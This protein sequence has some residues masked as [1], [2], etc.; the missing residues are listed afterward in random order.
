MYPEP[1]HNFFEYTI[2]KRDVAPAGQIYLGTFLAFSLFFSLFFGNILFFLI[3]LIISIFIFMEKDEEVTDEF[4]NVRVG[5]YQDGFHFANKDYKYK[6]V[7]S[8]SF[9]EEIFGTRQEYLRITFK[10]PAHPDL[11]IFIPGE[12]QKRMVYD[13]IR[14]SVKED[15][16]KELSFTEQI[17]LRFF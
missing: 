17:V 1:L 6:D 13:I 10:S 12:M 14:K 2:P 8:F 3:V 4:G 5:F 7:F 9:S 11:F 15:S 16:K